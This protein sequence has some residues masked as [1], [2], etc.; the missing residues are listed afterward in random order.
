MRI[1][2]IEKNYAIDLVMGFLFITTTF[3]WKNYFTHIILGFA[4]LLVLVAHLWLHKEWMIYQAI[5]IIKRTKRSSGGITRVNFLVDLFIGMMFIASIVSG[6]II[7]VYDSVVWGGLHSFMS[8]MVF[9]GCL[10]H[11]FLHFTWI[12]D[13]TRRLVTRRIKI[14]KDRHSIL[15]KQI[16]HN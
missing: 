10:V 9:L 13:I 4:L 8:W 7:I 11:L 2:R 1:G 14:R 15:Q 16:L 12:I 6:L 5:L 3:T